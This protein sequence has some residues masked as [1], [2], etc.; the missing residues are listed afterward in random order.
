MR[1]GAGSVGW[2]PAPTAGLHVVP[3]ERMDLD[4]D[5]DVKDAGC[6]LQ[7]GGSAPIH[8]EPVEE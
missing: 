1:T 7:L 4:V 2:A 6:M 8:V 5:M 3:P